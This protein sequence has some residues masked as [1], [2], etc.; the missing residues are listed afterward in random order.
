QQDLGVQHLELAL[1]THLGEKRV[2]G[3]AHPLLGGHPIGHDDRTPL[4]LPGLDAAANRGGVLVAELAKLVR[5]PRG[6]ITGGAV[7]DHALRVVGDD[8]LD[9]IDYVDRTDQLG[10]V[11]MRLE[12]L[13]RLARVD[14]RDAPPL[15]LTLG[16]GGLDLFDPLLDLLDR[17]GAGHQVVSSS[18]SKCVSASSSPTVISP[19][20]GYPSSLQS[21]APPIIEATFVKP[22]SLR[23]AS[24]VRAERLPS[25]Q[26][27]MIRSP[28]LAPA[29]WI[30][31][32]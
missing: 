18:P 32:R 27:K 9:S 28:S 6:A 14:Q 15:K 20:I 22:C 26:I 3:V 4:G 30:P 11:D 17:L 31:P 8:L 23:R 21:F 12:V 2:A 10:A 29:F 25:P 5:R 13:V 19:S 7:E 16:L 1:D 24:A